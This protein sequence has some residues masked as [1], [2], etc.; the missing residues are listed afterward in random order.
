MYLGIC[1]FDLA[2]SNKPTRQLPILGTMRVHSVIPVGA[3]LYTRD[4]SCFTDCCW[5]DATFHL[6]CDGWVRNSPD[7]PAPKCR[8]PQRRGPA[9][10]RSKRSK[11]SVTDTTTAADTTTL[12]D[13]A[14]PLDTTIAADTTTPTDTAAQD[15]APTPGPPPTPNLR[16][17]TT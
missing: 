10:K 9:T 7:A 17:A 2:I 4:T 3:E 11:R 13:T 14:A 8:K 16:S 6:K 1:H 15:N 12:E 5:S